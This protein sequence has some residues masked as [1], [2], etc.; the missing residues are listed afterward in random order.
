[1]MGH[2]AK[3]IL[4]AIAGLVPKWTCRVCDKPIRWRSRVVAVHAVAS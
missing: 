3:P 2:I 4:N 1:M